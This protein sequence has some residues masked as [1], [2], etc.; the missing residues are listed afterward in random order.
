MFSCPMENLKNSP[1]YVTVVRQN[2]Q[3][4][5]SKEMHVNAISR[6]TRMTKS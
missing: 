5:N 3:S 2:E 4:E 6:K 1:K